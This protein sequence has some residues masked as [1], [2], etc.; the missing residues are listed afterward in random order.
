MVPTSTH[1][2]PSLTG[3][4]DGIFNLFSRFGSNGGS[5]LGTGSSDVSNPS[6]ADESSPAKTP[7]EYQQALAVQQQNEL[8]QAQIEEEQL[9]VFDEDKVQQVALATFG[10]HS[11]RTTRRRM[12]AQ[13]ILPGSDE[14]KMMQLAAA[15]T[16]N[17]DDALV[18]I[19]GEDKDTDEED[20]DERKKR[21]DDAI[22]A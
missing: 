6:G 16:G 21:P 8:E 17:E 4:Q 3:I 20:D 1:S 12:N 9:M 5:P 7:K 11:G 22:A 15:T 14:Y 19:G 18:G 10:D 13:I 2:L